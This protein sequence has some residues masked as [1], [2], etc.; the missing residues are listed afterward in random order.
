MNEN[1]GINNPTSWDAEW[2]K[3][4]NH[5]QQDLRHAYY[6]SAILKK[7]EKKILELGAGSFRDVGTLNNWGIACYGIDYSI[8]AVSM[9]KEKFPK[10]IDK[11]SLDDCFNLKY[12][13][14]DFD[15]SYHNGLWGYFSDDDILKLV[16]EQAR[17]TRSRIIATVHNAH[18]K[19]FVEYFEKLKQDE[20]LYN[21]RFF[22]MEEVINFMMSVAKSVTIIPVGK[23]KKYFED[24]LINLGIG[25]PKNIKRSFDYH[26]LDLLDSSERLMCIGTF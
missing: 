8:E 1:Y 19:S 2:Q 4:F 12:K 10:F 15:L 5:Y 16:K 17:V 22:E 25:T 23:G 21:L 11:I 9:A 26:Q 6:I 3:Q 14:K 13:D 7:N 20:P 18:N 24:D